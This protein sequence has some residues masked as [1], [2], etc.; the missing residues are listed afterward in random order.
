[1]K[2]Y[3]TNMTK[4]QIN[5]V[6]EGVLSWP[7]E[8]QEELIEVAREIEAR[9]TGSYRAA[10]EELRAIDEADRSGVATEKEVEAAF[11][12]SAVHES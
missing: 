1:M 4:E 3:S 7:E 8:D 11:R 10:P 6:L 9:R 2:G 5:A 12:T